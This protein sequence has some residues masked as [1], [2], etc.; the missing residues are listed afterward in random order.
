[1]KYGNFLKECSRNG[2]YIIPYNILKVEIKRCKM[3]V[4]STDVYI[5]QVLKNNRKKYNRYF[6]EKVSKFLLIMR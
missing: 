1:M 2:G 4:F 5:K 3:N 6:R